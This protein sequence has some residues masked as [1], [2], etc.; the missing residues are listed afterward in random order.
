MKLTAA[1]SLIFL[2]TMPL[3]VSAT[4][5]TMLNVGDT[6]PSIAAISDQSGRQQSFESLTGEKGLVL[7]FIRSLV[8][9]AYC[10]RQILSINSYLPD[11]QA[12]GYGVAIISYDDVEKA[13]LFSQKHGIQIP[14]LSDSHSVLIRS[15]RLLDATQTTES[16]AYG[17]P[18]PTIY[19]INAQGVVTSRLAEEGYEN[20]PGIQDVLS[21]LK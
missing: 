17:I 16:Y 18:M 4:S 2:V 6:I 7:V 14:L 8:W 1:L 10:Q 3:P 21:A 15:F 12:A 5:S 11:F 13:N 19:V 9:C 20:R